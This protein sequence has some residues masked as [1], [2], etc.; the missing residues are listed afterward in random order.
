MRQFIPLTQQQPQ[1]PNQFAP[2]PQ[3]QS[4]EQHT[5]LQGVSNQIAS[6][7][8]PSIEAITNGQ[9]RPEDVFMKWFNGMN[10]QQKNCLKKAMNT[11][12]VKNLFKSFGVSE[13]NYDM[14]FRLINNSN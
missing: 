14:A 12:L 10:R 6:Q 4:P 11:G 7:L 5:D 1:Q 13:A 9:A 2:L 3:Q 8:K